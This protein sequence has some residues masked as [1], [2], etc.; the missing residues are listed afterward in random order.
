MARAMQ[1]DLAEK[2]EAVMMG[3][4]IKPVAVD[5]SYKAGR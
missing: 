2:V 4:K 5:R 1:R 3:E